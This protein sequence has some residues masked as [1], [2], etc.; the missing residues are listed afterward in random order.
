MG[1]PKKTSNPNG[2]IDIDNIVSLVS[3]GS[4][5]LMSANQA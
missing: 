3:S 1:L 4:K 5:D 2:K